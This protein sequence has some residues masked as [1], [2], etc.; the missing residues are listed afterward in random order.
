[1]SIENGAYLSPIQASSVVDSVVSRLVSAI[2][3]GELK[4][5]MKIPTEPDLVKAFGVGRSTIREAIRILVSYGILEV[6]RADGTYVCNGF[7][8]KILSPTLYGIVL[9]KESAHHDLIGLRKLLD[10]GILEQLFYEGVS[11]EI[12]DRLYALQDDLEVYLGKIIFTPSQKKTSL[13][14]ES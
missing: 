13:S 1:M 10:N 5:G 6:R 2:M 14:I 11:Q 12:W 3:S 9:Q 7:S 4:P 8:P